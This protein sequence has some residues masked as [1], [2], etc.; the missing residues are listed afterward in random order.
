[1]TTPRPLTPGE[2]PTW[3]VDRLKA[4]EI[5]MLTPETLAVVVEPTIGADLAARGL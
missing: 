4:D 5:M 2:P 1:M 3:L